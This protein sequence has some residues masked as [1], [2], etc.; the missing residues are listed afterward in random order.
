M[1]TE[2]TIAK[3]IAFD[4]HEGQFRKNGHPY[5]K[6]LEMVVDKVSEAD[7]KVIAWLHDVLED[8]D[9]KI[10]E[11]KSKGISDNNIE[12]IQILTLKR[13]QRFEDYIDLIK[14]NELATKVKIADLISN[15]SDNPSNK[16][17]VKFSK[18]L[19]RLCS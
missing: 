17:I 2:I 7:A 5:T 12:A 19:I 18:A 8:T 15:L 1:K 6:H 4:A 10:H 3:E 9:V 13:E 11:L 14:K 16:Q